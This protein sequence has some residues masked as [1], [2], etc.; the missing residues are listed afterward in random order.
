MN[1]QRGCRGDCMSDNAQN[2]FIQ[3]FKNK[4]N[5]KNTAE[6]F[7]SVNWMLFIFAQ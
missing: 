3:Q 6:I 7:P 1:S 5:K 4:S 2:K